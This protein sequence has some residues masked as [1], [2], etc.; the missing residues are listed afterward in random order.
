MIVG[1][2]ICDL[3][4]VKIENIGVFYR[5]S[6]EIPTHIMWPVMWVGGL[7]G[8]IRA[9]NAGWVDGRIHGLWAEMYVNIWQPYRC[10]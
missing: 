7:A 5:I 2:G 3:L 10:V 8:A 1:S 4:D 6:V 9:F